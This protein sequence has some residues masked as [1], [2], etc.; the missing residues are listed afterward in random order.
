MTTSAVQTIDDQAGTVIRHIGTGWT[1]EL[2]ADWTPGTPNNLRIYGRNAHHDLTWTA[3][4]SGTV[5]GTVR[6]D[7]AGV[8]TSVTGSVPEFRF[9]GSW[10]DDVTKLSWVVTR[11]YA[12]AQGRFISEDSLLGQPRDPDSRHLYAY[13]AGDPVGAW[14]PDGQ[15]WYVTSTGDTLW[16]LAAAYLH[17]GG[18]W[19]LIVRANPTLLTLMPKVRVRPGMC[20]WIPVDH[21]SSGSCDRALY[22]RYDRVLSWM[23]EQMRSN[24]RQYEGFLDRVPPDGG[25]FAGVG[26]VTSVTL[27]FFLK[28]GPGGEWDHKKQLSRLVGVDPR[29]HQGDLLPSGRRVNG[30]Y[31]PIRGDPIDERLYY[32]VWSNIHY[33]YVG[34]AIGFGRRFLLEG[35]N[36]P[37]AGQSGPADDLSVRIGMDLW[38]SSRSLTRGGLQAAIVAHLP[39]YRR[40]SNSFFKWVIPGLEP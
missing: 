18:K 7:P 5:T 40:F 4:A 14:D 21:R 20:L 34:R 28:V 2:L 35:Q 1:G 15:L 31:T 39:S 6:Y 22:R 30:F 29:F 3:G 25:I 38:D 36:N 9:Q 11:W 17:G 26:W 32:D 33:G 10:A 19:P 12:P 16:S 8:A 23:T 24:G 13:G 27:W 37:L